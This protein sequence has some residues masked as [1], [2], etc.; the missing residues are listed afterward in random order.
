MMGG[1]QELVELSQLTSRSLDRPEQVDFERQCKVK[2][3]MF[4]N[5]SNHFSFQ[6]GKIAKTDRE[7]H[8]YGTFV[9]KLRCFEVDVS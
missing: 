3:D 8:L 2:F 9:D 4:A 1:S 6:G 5:S 7:Y